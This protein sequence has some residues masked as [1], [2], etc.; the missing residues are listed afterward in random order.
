MYC[1][2]LMFSFSYIVYSN[3]L[4]PLVYSNVCIH[5]FIQMFCI[6]LRPA[7]FLLHPEEQN[8]EQLLPNK[9][10]AYHP[11]SRTVLSV[12]TTFNNFLV[13][14]ITHLTAEPTVKQKMWFKTLS[15]SFRTQSCALDNQV[16]LDSCALGNQVWLDSCALD[17]QV[18]LDSCALCFVRG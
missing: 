16:W 15:S 5:L 13:V 7:S 14:W 4:Y 11:L 18:W 8:A 2:H 12:W 3:D 1:I 17:N 9:V 6:H 10:R